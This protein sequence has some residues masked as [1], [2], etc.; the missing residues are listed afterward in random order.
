MNGSI[1]SSWSLLLAFFPYRT[2]QTQ[3][4]KK[5]A[6]LQTFIQRD[7]CGWVRAIIALWSFFSHSA[8]VLQGLLES[9]FLSKRLTSSVRAFLFV[10]SS[11]IDCSTSRHLFWAV[12][13]LESA[14]ASCLSQLKSSRCFSVTDFFNSAIFC[15]KIYLVQPM[16]PNW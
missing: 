10:S 5:I 6:Q 12:L 9:T 7:L 11:S 8:A 16:F 4:Q 3:K 13:R 14:S 15:K 2:T 1:D